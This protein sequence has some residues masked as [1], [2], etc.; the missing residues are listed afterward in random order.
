MEVEDV[1][2]ML[3]EVSIEEEKGLVRDRDSANIM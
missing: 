2:S 1:E 3:Q